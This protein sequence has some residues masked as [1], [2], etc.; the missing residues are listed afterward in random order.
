MNAFVMK[1]ERGEKSPH[2]N[3]PQRLELIPFFTMR[4]D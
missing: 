1:K 4:Y 3:D 2:T